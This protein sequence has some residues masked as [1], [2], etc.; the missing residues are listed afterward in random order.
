MP[1]LKV[2]D[3]NIPRL[4]SL[5]LCRRQRASGG[6]S[7]DLPILFLSSRDDEEPLLRW[8]RAFR[9]GLLLCARVLPTH[10]APASAGIANADRRVNY[11]PRPKAVRS[12]SETM[13]RAR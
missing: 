6:A 11:G 10:V 12:K 1:D 9:I 8:L 4:D 2:L 13:H 5:E 3:I 7:A